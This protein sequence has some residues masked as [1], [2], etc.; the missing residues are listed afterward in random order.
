MLRTLSWKLRSQSSCVHSRIEPWC[1]QPAQLKRMFHRARLLDEG[2]HGVVVEDI[3]LRARDGALI[4]EGLVE[5]LGLEIGGHD[6]RALAHEGVHRGASHA[7]SRGGHEGALA[8]Q[9]I[10]HGVEIPCGRVPE[11]A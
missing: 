2:A 4:R 5:E 1:T 3:Q 6:G 9:A 11:L 8:L 10:G 7:L